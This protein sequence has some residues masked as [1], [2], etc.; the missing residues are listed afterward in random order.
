ML[1]KLQRPIMKV[2]DMRVGAND[3]DTNPVN[4]NTKNLKKKLA[5]NVLDVI[6]QTVLLDATS[7]IMFLFQP[8]CL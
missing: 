8:I 1:L 4:R 5:Q 3:T 7:A 2:N 6:L